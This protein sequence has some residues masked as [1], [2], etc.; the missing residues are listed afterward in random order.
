MAM[1]DPGLLY[2]DPI[3]TNFSVGFQD[4]ALYGD[5]IFP[6]TPVNTQSGRYR[7]FD[8]S[9]WIIFE[10]VR[11]PGGVS[12]EIS[13]AKWSED[14]FETKERSLQVAILDEERQQLQS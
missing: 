12:N 1:Y 4:Q 8:R 10:S 3:L 2:Q 5:R 6:P 11:E 13:G 9:N 14:T 7:V